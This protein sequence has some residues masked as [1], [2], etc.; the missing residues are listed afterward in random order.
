[1]KGLNER[2][3]SMLNIV[4][5]LPASHRH[6]N[7][8]ARRGGWITWEALE[9]YDWRTTNALIRRGL[10]EISQYGIRATQKEVPK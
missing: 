2:Q 1:M 7:I 9:I 4:K 6:F 10:V 3:Q 5:T 8:P